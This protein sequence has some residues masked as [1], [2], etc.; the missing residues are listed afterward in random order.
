[1][2]SPT[3]E[4]RY[5]YY[6]TSMYYLDERYDDVIEYAVPIL[7]TSKQ[8]YESEM[9]SIIAASYFAKSDYVN[10][11][12]YFRDFYAKD[13]SKNKNN[14]FTYQYGY[15]LFELKKYSESVAVLEKL[16][17]D[18]VYLQSGMYTLGR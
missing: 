9:L 16:D 2:G 8:E 14:L 7:K 12:K 11:E 10:A 1:K 6:I 15:A 18:D 17:T 13:K 3:Y 5:P 4:A